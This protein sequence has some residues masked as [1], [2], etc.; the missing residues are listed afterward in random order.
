MAT[1][2]RIKGRRIDPIGSCRP[3]T[4]EQMEALQTIQ[5]NDIILISDAIGPRMGPDFITRHGCRLV[6]VD[7]MFTSRYSTRKISM[8]VRAINSLNPHD[9]VMYRRFGKDYWYHHNQS[10]EFL[11]IEYALTEHS[12]MDVRPSDDTIFHRLFRST[13]PYEACRQ[14]LVLVN[15]YSARVLR[16]FREPVQDRE[17]TRGNTICAICMGT[18]VY[19]EH[20]EQ[21][22]K[23]VAGPA[24]FDRS[25][26]EEHLQRVNARRHELLY[27]PILES[28]LPT[29][30]SIAQPVPVSDLALTQMALPDVAHLSLAGESDG[31]S[32]GATMTDAAQAGPSS[33]LIQFLSQRTSSS[34][35][36]PVIRPGLAKPTSIKPYFFYKKAA[37]RV[38][39]NECQVCH[40]PFEEGGLIAELPCWHFFHAACYEKWLWQKCPLRCNA[41]TE[42]H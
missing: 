37:E 5:P 15:D 7:R 9:W 38:L 40:E 8:F 19:Q 26:Y 23:F 1:V 21:V 42:P 31:R 20:E 14:G 22:A 10:K 24:D 11:Q 18:R 4:G 30:L 34:V 28:T 13:C 41:D 29:Q 3:M 39:D 12:H 16:S 27:V 17:I 6:M 25:E 36:S 2:E 33:A 32:A 35:S